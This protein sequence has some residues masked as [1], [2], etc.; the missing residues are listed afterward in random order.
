MRKNQIYLDDSQ[1]SDMEDSLGQFREALNYIQW[2]I[3]NGNQ[4]PPNHRQMDW[5][6]FMQVYEDATETLQEEINA[7]VEDN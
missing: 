3:Q 2:K 1:Y 4:N 7:P 6:Q 5:N